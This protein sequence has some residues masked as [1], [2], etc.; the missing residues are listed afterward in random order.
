MTTTPQDSFLR[1]ASAAA[2]AAGHIFPDYAACEAALESTWGR[3]RLAR[4]ANNLFGQKESAQSIEKAEAI[5]GVGTLA[6]PTQEY[7]NGR[8]VTVIARWARFA[9]Q[10][11]CFRAR[12]ALLRRL[13][14]S[15]PAYARALAATTGEAFVEEVSRAWS[16]DPQR[17][18][19]VLAIHRQHC[20]SFLP[21][22]PPLVAGPLA[23]GLA[24]V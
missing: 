18:A 22:P 7:L 8:W 16:T 14:Q 23:A 9:D 19:K 15:Y 24:R 17:A 3:S 12:M 1:Q 2:R 21:L 10:S 6:L 13:Q 5:E 11:A 20:A 4:E